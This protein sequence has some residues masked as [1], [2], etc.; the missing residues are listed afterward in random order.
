MRAIKVAALFLGYGL[1]GF[2]GDYS[3]ALLARDHASV[4][5]IRA[6]APMT[7][8]RAADPVV[9]VHVRMHDQ[10]SCRYEAERSVKLEASTSQMLHLVAGAG[11]LTV[12]GVPG[13]EEVRAVG[14]ACAS[15]ESYL[16]ELQVTLDRTGDGLALKTHYPRRGWRGEGYARIDLRVEVPEGMAAD[17]KDSSGDLEVSGTGALRLSDSSGSLRVDHVDGPVSIDDS[18]GGIEVSDVTGDV[19]IRD[20]S[21]G[22]D[23]RDVQGSVH[24]T[25]GSGSIDV[26]GVGRDVI[27]GADG[28]GSI[29]VR[30]VKGDFTVRHDG[31]GSI[32]YSDVDGTVSVPLKKR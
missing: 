32:R 22:I 7:A 16:D 20:G 21:G 27:V 2:T 8:A 12:K 23:V 30:R 19:A 18:S 6:V 15:S 17:V 29:D 9:R 31:S 4:R 26:A 5:G 10:G 3:M 28:S 14:H 13:L 24:L 11:N 1:V 25:D